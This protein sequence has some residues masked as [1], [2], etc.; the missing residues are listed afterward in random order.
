[1]KICWASNAP[2]APTGYGQQTAQMLPR[3]RDAGHQV[4]VAANFGVQGGPLEWD[5]FRIY[6]C[7]RDYSNDTIPL[8]AMHWFD[9]DPGWLIFLYDAWTLRNPL[10]AEMNTAVWV[11]I[12][13]RPAPPLVVQHFKDYGSVP[14]AMS[15][16]GEE[17][18]RAS[19][20]EPLY[21]PH[22]IDTNVFVAHDKAEAK[23]ALGVPEDRFL[24]GMMSTNNSAQPSR[25]AYPEAFAAF[26]LFAHDKPD[27]LLYVHA[28]KA[29]AQGGME[30]DICAQGRGIRPDQLAFVD[31][32]RYR[33]GAISQA[34]LAWIY[35]AFDVLLFPSMGEG[36]GIPAI[37]AQACG[38]PIIVSDYS[39]QTELVAPGAGYLVAAQPYWDSPQASDFC[40]PS[41]ED[42]YDSLSHAYQ[43]RDRL[44]AW[45]PQCREFA[46][47]YDA[48]RVFGEYWIPILDRLEAELP[49]VE[50]IEMRR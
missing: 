31:Q 27:A 22:G 37:E 12:D 44:A 43:N 14:I 7:G 9:R 23:K 13:H 36:F 15:R 10:Y 25:K 1:M 42:I 8:H 21:A 45:G 32:Y 50:P 35:S 18:L 6:P 16:F 2:Q 39:A 38:T 41:I 20:L 5:G 34:E 19:G 47:Q 3:L 49:T 48:D 29:G 30:L 11:P 24:V 40:I 46:L 33:A 28:E 26:S 17:Q 4:A